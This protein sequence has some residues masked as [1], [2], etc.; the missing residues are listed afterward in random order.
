[1]RRFILSEE[2]AEFLREVLREKSLEALK[3]RDIEIVKRLAR[4]STS[5]YRNQP[6]LLENK[7]QLKENLTTLYECMQDSNYDAHYK[8]R[9]FLGDIINGIK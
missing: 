2:D 9:D 7:E 3:R 1:M 4:I 5:S 8:Q 6:I